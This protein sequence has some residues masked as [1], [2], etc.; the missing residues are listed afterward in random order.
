MKF[1]IGVSL[2]WKLILMIFSLSV[3]GTEIEEATRC[4]QCHGGTAAVES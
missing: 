2:R 1:K 3:F 4:L